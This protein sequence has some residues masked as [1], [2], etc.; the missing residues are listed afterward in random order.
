MVRLF[1]KRTEPMELKLF[2]KRR[3]MTLV[4]RHTGFHTVLRPRNF[5]LA[6][7]VISAY[8]GQ[9]SAIDDPCGHHVTRFF[10]RAPPSA[11]KEYLVESYVQ[12]TASLI[13]STCLVAL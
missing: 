4:Q 3:L 13:G 9:G 2:C 7:L 1:G 10:N 12:K 11:I 6:A 8:Q 5:N